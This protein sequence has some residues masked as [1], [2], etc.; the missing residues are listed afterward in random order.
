[1]NLD[2]EV[3]M[4]D[5][6]YPMT[7]ERATDFAIAASELL[8]EAIERG[9]QDTPTVRWAVSYLLRRGEVPRAVPRSD[10]R[11]DGRLS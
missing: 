6:R 3:P 11:R 10:S 1:M 8:N 5:G 7:A 4:G 9:D 2:R